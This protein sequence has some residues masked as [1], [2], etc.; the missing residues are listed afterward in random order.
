M[1]LRQQEKVG[2]LGWRRNRLVLQETSQLPSPRRTTFTSESKPEYVAA[3]KPTDHTFHKPVLIKVNRGLFWTFCWRTWS[4]KSHTAAEK[5]AV[6]RDVPSHTLALCLLPGTEVCVLKWLRK[7][8]RIWTPLTTETLFCHV[9]SA[10]LKGHDCMVLKSILVQCLHY[11][12]TW[13]SWS[14]FSQTCWVCSHGLVAVQANRATHTQFHSII[15][16]SDMNE[17]ESWKSLLVIAP[18]FQSH[19]LLAL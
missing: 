8:W 1:P 13:E 2:P 12:F 17:K 19:W 14:Y 4:L 15:K 9:W 3:T 18:T 11:I 6:E 10:T 5:E 7:P 16:K